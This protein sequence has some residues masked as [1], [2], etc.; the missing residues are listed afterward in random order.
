MIVFKDIQLIYAELIDLE[1]DI[2]AVYNIRLN[3]F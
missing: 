2:D 1:Q 3:L